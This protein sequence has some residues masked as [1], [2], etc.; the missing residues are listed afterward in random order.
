MFEQENGREIPRN[1]RLER[2]RSLSI[3][4]IPVCG[5]DTASALLMT[6]RDAENPS[7][8]LSCGTWSLIG[9]FC[10]EGIGQ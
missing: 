3:D 8:F 4:V 6:E 9:N 1:A 10:R 5:H 7:L 2:L